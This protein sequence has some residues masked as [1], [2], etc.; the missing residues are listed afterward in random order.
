VASASVHGKAALT[1]KGQK[2]TT[3]ASGAK[4]PSNHVPQ[5][6]KAQVGKQ[7]QGDYSAEQQ[8][9]GQ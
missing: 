8:Q 4:G 9:G 6:G 2:T 3:P 5:L 7:G 1:G